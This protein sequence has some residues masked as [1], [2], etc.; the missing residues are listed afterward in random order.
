VFKKLILTA[1][2]LIA[3]ASAVAQASTLTATM[4][5]TARVVGTCT[6]SVSASPNFGTLAIGALASNAD[7]A[8]TFA[9]NCS[10]NLSPAITLDNGLNAVGAQRYIKG[11][12]TPANT[13]PYNLYSDSARSVAWA[14][15]AV[16]ANGSPQTVTVYA[17]IPSGTAVPNF[18][19]TYNDTVTATLT[20]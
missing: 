9:V 16:T 20:Y 10:N 1:A 11:V 2:V 6:F 14:S 4:T 12:T 5:P 8:G 3:S 7:A 13:L 19:D 17:R 18:Q 15:V